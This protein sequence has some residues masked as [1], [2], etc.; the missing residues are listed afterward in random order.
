MVNIARLEKTEA[1]IAPQKKPRKNS[2]AKP[3][4][5]ITSALVKA[6]T[7][8]CEIVSDVLASISFFHRRNSSR[9]TFALSLS[10]TLFSFKPRH[11]ELHFDLLVV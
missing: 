1:K 6:I 8:N 3:R 4:T 9:V 2:P 10:G 5:N 11:L 7:Y